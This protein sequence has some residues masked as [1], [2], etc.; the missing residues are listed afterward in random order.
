MEG[1]S[2]FGAPP[3]IVADGVCDN[4]GALC[5]D[6]SYFGQQLQQAAVARAQRAPFS[7]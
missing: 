7:L 3:E 1:G 2:A 6:V 5:K 4:D